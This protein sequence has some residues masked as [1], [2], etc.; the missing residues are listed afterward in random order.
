MK[1]DQSKVQNTWHGICQLLWGGKA[2]GT[3]SI[4]GGILPCEFLKCHTQGFLSLR[5]WLAIKRK[6]NILGDSVT[7][8]EKQ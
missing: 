6:K 1:F 7:E 5:S 4:K 2:L 3:A 8:R